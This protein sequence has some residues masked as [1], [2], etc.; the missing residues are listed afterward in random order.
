RNPHDVGA[1]AI[2][3]NRH[4]L[5]QIGASRNGLFEAMD[6]GGHCGRDGKMWL[7]GRIVRSPVALSS[8]AR[9]ES[10]RTAAAATFSASRVP[11]KIFA[12]VCSTGN[13]PTVHRIS[14]VGRGPGVPT[15]R[16]TLDTS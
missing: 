2:F 10:R 11:E 12:V 15:R 6:G 16:A 13:S 1:P 4:D 8:E 5:D 14:T 7:S 3:G 9:A